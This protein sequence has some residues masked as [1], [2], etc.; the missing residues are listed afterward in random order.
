MTD[1]GQLGHKFARALA[2][3]NGQIDVAHSFASS[4]SFATQG[5]KSAHA[6]LVARAS[7]FDALAYPDLFLGK[8]LVELRVLL[9]LRLQ[10]FG[11]ATLPVAEVA[12]K[13]EQLPSI[14]FDNAG[15]DGIKEAPVMRNEDNGATGG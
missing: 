3:G 12:R 11:L 5:L 1:V 4:G 15:G 10:P 14:E 2:L 7:C 13:A 9:L 6:S 8:H